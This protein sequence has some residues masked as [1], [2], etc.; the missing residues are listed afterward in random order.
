MPRSGYTDR[1]LTRREN[2]PRYLVGMLTE[3]AFILGL[4]LVAVLIAVLAMVIYR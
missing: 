1:G 3:T 4:T 2:W